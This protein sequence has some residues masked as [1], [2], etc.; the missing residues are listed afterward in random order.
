MGKI[1][2]LSLTPRGLCRV[3]AASYVGVSP[4]LFDE[5]VR[6][7]RMPQP[8]RI[9]ARKVFDIRKLDLAFDA[10]PGDESDLKTWDVDLKV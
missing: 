10:L 9:N 3:Q 6:D 8:K 1:P 2:P 4:S 5:M 7:G